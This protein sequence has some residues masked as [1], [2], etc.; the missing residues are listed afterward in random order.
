MFELSVCAMDRVGIDRDLTDY[1]SNRRELIASLQLSA[2][3]RIDNL[4][5]ELTK[6][7]PIRAGVEAKDDGRVLAWHVLVH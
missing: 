2:L 4:I 3:D 7:C 6:G 1:F 5:Y